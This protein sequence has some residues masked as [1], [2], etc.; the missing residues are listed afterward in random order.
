M[1]A[2]EAQLTRITNNID[3]GNDPTTTTSCT[4]NIKEKIVG[5]LGVD[6]ATSPTYGEKLSYLVGQKGN[7]WVQGDKVTL[8]RLSS[9]DGKTSELLLLTDDQQ[10][11][12][13]HQKPSPQQSPQRDEAELVE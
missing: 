7:G 5:R 11:D 3:I 2:G 8:I 12:Q 9:S 10:Q 13:H 6:L 4:S 1:S